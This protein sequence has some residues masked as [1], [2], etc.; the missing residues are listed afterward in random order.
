MQVVGA[1]HTEILLVALADVAAVVVVLLTGLQV[2]EE[3]LELQ[4]AVPVE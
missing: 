3:I 2:L 4:M 1:V